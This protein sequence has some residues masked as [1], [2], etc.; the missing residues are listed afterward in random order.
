VMMLTVLTHPQILFELHGEDNF[1]AVLTLK[2]CSI[3]TASRTSQGYQR[4][5]T[6]HF[7]RRIRC[8]TGS[9]GQ[10]GPYL[11]RL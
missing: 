10:S 6:G 2:E 11:R 9:G 5:Q 8:A 4:Y 7:G 3:G 1:L